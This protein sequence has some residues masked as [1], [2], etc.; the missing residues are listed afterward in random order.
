M[1]TRGKAPSEGA[2]LNELTPSRNGLPHS[3]TGGREHPIGREQVSDIQ[4]ARMLAA[5][6]EVVNER[7]A[8]NVT[9]AHIVGRSGVSRR[10]FYEMFVDREACLLAAFDDAIRRIA[11]VVVPAYVEPLRW[12]EKIR[13]GLVALLEFLDCERG[14]GRLA[15]VETL[16]AGANALERRRSVLAEVIAVVDE[17]RS[18]VK[19]GEGPPPMAAEGIVGGVLA[20]LHSRLLEGI[21]DSPPELAGPR[22]AAS[23]PPPTMR[24]PR[25]EDPEGGSLLGLAGPLMSMIVLPYLGAAAARR[26]LRQPVPARHAKPQTGPAD[27]L[28]DLDMRLTYRTVRV[29]MA[30]AELGG[31]GSYPSNRQV[32]VA[33]GTQDQ[34]QIS[35]LLSRLHRLGLIHNAGVGP[36]KGAPNAWT[37]TPKGAEIERTI[38]RQTSAQHGS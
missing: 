27:P 24:G 28:R 11:T 8:A 9:V 7:G 17:G 38:G 23:P 30:V 3:G 25:I 29:L 15:I 19:H 5:L 2:A 18:E 6:V 35:K 33:A 26:E 4:R 14:I 37:L 32:G 21:D 20:V 10:T 31:R 1:V 13:A 16:G 22:T 36:G 34:G 12:R